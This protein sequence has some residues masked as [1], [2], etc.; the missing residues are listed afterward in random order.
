MFEKTS[1]DVQTIFNGTSSE[2]P[3][4][5][6]FP[7]CCV[8]MAAGISQRFQ[9]LDTDNKLLVEFKGKPM[10]QWALDNFAQLNCHSR[11]VVARKDEIG[12][13]VPQDSFQVIWNTGENLSP[14]VTIRKAILAVPEDSMGCLFAVGDQPFLTHSSIR[15]LCEVFQ[16]N[17]DKIVSLSWNQKRGNPVIFPRSLFPELLALE[18]GLSGRYVLNRHPELLIL[19]EAHNPE[20]LMDIDTRQQYTDAC[21]GRHPRTHP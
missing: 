8:I 7:L 18:D 20:E 4:D 9:E 3:P 21:N 15:R 13:M 1:S 19:V 14:T 5:T 10:L 11:I 6:E 12:S 17:P 16:E 2:L